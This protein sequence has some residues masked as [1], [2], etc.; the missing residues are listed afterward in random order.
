MIFASDLDRTL[1][2]SKRF[3]FSEKEHIPVEWK[4]GRMI[5][6]MERE[7]I[8]KLSR[9]NKYENFIP[10]TTRTEEEFKRIH[11]FQESILPKHVVVGN[12][13]EILELKNGKLEKDACWETLINGKLADIKPLDEIIKIIERHTP[14]NIMKFYD[15]RSGAF[16]YGRKLSSDP[17]SR[18]FEVFLKDT[19]L[20]YN[21]KLFIQDR[22]IFL[23]PKFINKWDPVNY[24]REKIGVQ[25]VAAAGDSFMDI[26]LIINSD[27]GFMPLHG[28]GRESADINDTIRI[29][30]RKGSKSSIEIMNDIEMF[31]GSNRLQKR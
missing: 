20:E 25:F 7:T 9:F 12:G 28:A 31:V 19:A 27:K 15:I 1:I 21:L 22:K 13:A 3:P 23:M 26:P 24:L 2:F 16:V 17:V 6:F 14:K 8:Q 29:T 4:D 18:K 30:K 5:S 10:V 11:V